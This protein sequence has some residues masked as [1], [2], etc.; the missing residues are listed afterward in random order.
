MSR[1]LTDHINQNQ[2]I[3]KRLVADIITIVLDSEVKPFVLLN[4][5]Y[6]AVS[7][8]KVAVFPY[9]LNFVDELTGNAATMLSDGASAATT[10]K[11]RAATQS[12]AAKMRE[13]DDAFIEG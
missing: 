8:F 6:D 13:E 1:T 2:L 10:R 11:V 12:D 9:I 3:S 7:D 4:F 5:Q